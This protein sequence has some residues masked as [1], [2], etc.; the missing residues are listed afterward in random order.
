MP[1]EGLTMPKVSVVIPAYNSMEYL[2]Q[3]LES[4]LQQ[5]FRDF[6]VLIVNDGSCDH[7]EQWGA[8][9]ADPRVKLISQVNQGVSAA[10]N[11]GIAQAQGE[12]IA[13]LDSDDLW[14]SSKLAKQVQCLEAEGEV[15]LVHTWMFFADEQ[16]KSTGRVLRS[17]AEGWV[18]EQLAERN[19]VACSSVMVRRSCL[20]SVGVF[21]SNLIPIEDWDLWIRIAS[22]YPFAVIRE[23]LMYYRKL[24]TSISTN[25]TSMERA[26]CILIEQT[27]QSAP[28]N[29]QFLKS[30][31][32]GHAYLCLAWKALQ[33]VNRDHKLA[34]SFQKKAI[35]YYP[36]FQFSKENLRLSVAITL[37]RLFGT[38]RYARTLSLL[39][40]L[41]QSFLER[42]KLPQAQSK[43]SS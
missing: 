14:E 17:D 35:A 31:S 9:L 5:S 4:V 36:K 43:S 21:D 1:T 37:M 22:R 11:A 41:R 24:P 19:M 18:W 26:F 15:G 34:T 40:K 3:T 32:Y 38:D 8:E 25:C 12:Y 30:R 6:E 13:F 16:G 7:I 23:P 29:L 28:S 10:R 42:N 2:P 27:F 39:Y 33:S 20:E